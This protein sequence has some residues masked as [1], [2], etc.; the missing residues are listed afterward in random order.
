MAGFYIICVKFVEHLL[1]SLTVLL[2]AVICM[3]VFDFTLLYSG[4]WHSY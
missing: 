4:G 2:T 3:T 1:Q